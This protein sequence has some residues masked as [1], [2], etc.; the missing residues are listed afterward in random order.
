MQ[1]RTK[2]LPL[3]IVKRR[4]FVRL[5]IEIG[6]LSRKYWIPIPYTIRPYINQILENVLN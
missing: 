2:A 4:G 5:I 3:T 6:G 1:S